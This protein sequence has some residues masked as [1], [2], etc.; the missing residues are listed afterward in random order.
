MNPL[1]IASISEI[2]RESAVSYGKAF[3]GTLLFGSGGA[4]LGLNGKEGV[5]LEVQWK[6]GSKS[7]IQVKQDMYKALVS[8]MYEE[9]TTEKQNKIAENEKFY[10]KAIIVKELGCGCLLPIIFFGII[11]LISS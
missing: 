6:N 5:L 1:T 4:A 3:G 8:V 11:L 10:D 9:F 2:S 7:L